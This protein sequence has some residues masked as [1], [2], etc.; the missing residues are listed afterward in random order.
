[1]KPVKGSDII[2][3]PITFD[4]GGAGRASATARP[5]WI[6][7]VFILWAMF[8]I[9]VFIVADGY[10]KFIY[11]AMAFFFLSYV[12]R[13]L[14]LRE[15]YFRKKRK[16]LI[17]HDYMFKHSIFWDIYDISPR[18]PHIVYF[19]SGLKGIFVALDKDVIVGKEDDYSY[20][21]HE[22]IAEAYHQMEKRG[23]ECIHIDY[24]DVIGK[25]TRMEHLFRQAEKIENPDLKRVMIHIYDHI[26]STM[27]K[28]FA[29][30][31]VYCFYSVAREDL[32]WDDLQVVLDCFLQANYIRARVLNRDEISVLVKSIMNIDEFSVNKAID[33]LFK[34]MNKVEYIRPIWTEKDGKR[35]IINKTLEEI[36]EAKRVY[37]SERKLKKKSRRK[38]FFKKKNQ[39][40]AD[41]DLFE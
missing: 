11:P 29:S 7:L 14:I 26:E 37:Q 25:D 12:V 39:V 34:E 41:I 36:E 8:S 15:K 10:K 24:M 16:E 1:M 19:G 21:H 28:S 23:I 22:A 32:F 2:Q 33:N 20:Y 6:W 40:E 4:V 9:I 17:E 30:Y 35:T 31:D 18:Y 5:L 38:G 3:I 27:N 13:F